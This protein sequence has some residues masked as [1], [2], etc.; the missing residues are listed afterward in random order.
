MQISDFRSHCVILYLRRSGLC[1]PTGSHRAV[2]NQRCISYTGVSK[3]SGGGG[4]GGGGRGRRGEESRGPEGGVPPRGR[5]GGRAPGSHA[6][7][8]GGRRDMYEALPRRGTLC[9][10]RAGRRSKVVAWGGC[11]QGGAF[12]S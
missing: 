9:R 10:A 3:G 7:A 8:G 5:A 2:D 11:A 1:N 4:G 6:H 12:L